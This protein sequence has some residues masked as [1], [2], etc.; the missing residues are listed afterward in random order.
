MRRMVFKTFMMVA[1]AQWMMK[2]EA[3]GWM[4]E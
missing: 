4:K 2:K 3:D 1:K